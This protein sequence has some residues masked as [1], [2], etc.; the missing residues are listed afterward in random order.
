MEIVELA[1]WITHYEALLEYY[2]KYGTC[3]IPQL[4]IFECYL[5]G[6]WYHYVGRLG[7]WLSTQRCCKAGTRRYSLLPKREALLQKLVDEG[8]FIL[9]VSIV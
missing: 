5:E 4:E 8:K 9:Y 6:G 3:N 7:T 1:D 2:K